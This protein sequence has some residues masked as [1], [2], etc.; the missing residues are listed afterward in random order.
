MNRKSV[1]FGLFILLASIICVVILLIFTT[2]HNVEF[3]YN[4]LP[5]SN[6]VLYSIN[7]E[8]LIH[9]YKEID[10]SK[11]KLITNIGDEK[12]SLRNGPYV[13]AISGSNIVKDRYAFTV[14]GQASS[15]KITLSYTKDY[16]DDLLVK[17]LPEIS[18]A[19][20]DSYPE[21]T[22]KYFMKPGRL[23]LDGSIFSTRLRYIG[24]DD[25]VRD[26]LI[27]VLRKS[28]KGWEVVTKPPQILLRYSDY[29][30]IPLSILKDI[31]QDEV[32]K[33]NPIER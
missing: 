22:T 24:D 23:Y 12:I 2:K 28:D 13:V 11:Q 26:T 30:T 21:I 32:I 14:D 27:V 10:L 9:D 18:Q 25:T 33:R 1:I 5:G 8:K 20:I 19:L 15:H 4:K 17:S 16:L 3:T 29:P 7:N 31:N 6:L